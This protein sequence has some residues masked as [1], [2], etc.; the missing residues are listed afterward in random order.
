MGSLFSRNSDTRC[1]KSTVTRCSITDTL[2]GAGLT[3]YTLKGREIN[4][5]LRHIATKRIYTLLPL[6]FSRLIY[7]P[8][9]S[10]KYYLLTAGYPRVLRVAVIQHQGPTPPFPHRARSP[11]SVPLPWGSVRR[12]CPTLSS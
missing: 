12:T 10:S 6:C 8:H 3:T 2:L 7:F 5:I 1:H 4:I 9:K 11:S